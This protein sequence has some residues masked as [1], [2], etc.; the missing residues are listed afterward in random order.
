MKSVKIYLS[1]LIFIK[2][3]YNGKYENQ[4]LDG[5]LPERA[6]EIFVHAVRFEVLQ[7]FVRMCQCFT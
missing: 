4:T 5:R 1:P 2:I 7:Q 6:T 3:C